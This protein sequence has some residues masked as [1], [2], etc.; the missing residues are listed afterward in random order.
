MTLSY[1]DIDNV[2]KLCGFF[3]R[4]ARNVEFPVLVGGQQGLRK[5]QEL[6][7]LWVNGR[8]LLP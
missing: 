2:D 3:R 5:L 6:A 4:E 8:E 1:S 7:R